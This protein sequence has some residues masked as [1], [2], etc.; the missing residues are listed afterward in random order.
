MGDPPAG[1]VVPQLHPLFAGSNFLAGALGGTAS[2]ALY[3]ACFP[4]YLSCWWAEAVWG[5]ERH[6]CLDVVSLPAVTLD[7][8]A[9]RVARLSPGAKLLVLLSDPVSA[10]FSTELALRDMGCSPRWSLT[11]GMQAP[12]AQKAADEASVWNSHAALPPDAPLPTDLAQRLFASPD[13]LPLL[14]AF[15]YAERL[16]PWLHHFARK[17]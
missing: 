12:A 16:Q 15:R 2:C 5:A 14:R 8:T 4:T 10:A 11:A 13:P 7:S 6:L 17:E 1:P 3:R 9:A